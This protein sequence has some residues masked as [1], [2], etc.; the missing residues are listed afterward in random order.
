VDARFPTEAKKGLIARFTK[1]EIESSHS[2][3]RTSLFSTRNKNGHSGNRHFARASAFDLG[4]PRPLASSGHPIPSMESTKHLI[5]G[6]AGHI[7]HGKSTLVEALTG[8]NPDRLE[9]EK[10]RG[11]TIDLGFAFLDLEGARLGFVDV[12]GHERFVRNML[13]GVG[14][15]HLVLLVIA[16]DESIK[17]Q[18]REH[19]DICR[20]LGIPRGIIAITKSDL[21]DADVLGLV[22]LEI[23]EFV[24]GSFLESAPIIPVSAR[25]GAGLDALKQ[26]LR[27][28]AQS[29]PP[30]DSTRHFRLPIDRSFAMKGFGTVVTGTLVSGAVKVEDE[31]E[32]YPPRLRARV[33]GLHSGGKSVARAV[34]GQ[35]TAVNLAGIE[36]EEIERGMVLAPPGIFE[37]ARRLDARITLLGSARPLGSRARVHF[38]QG[39]A[40]VIAEI[41]LLGGNELAPGASAFAQLR[42]EK[43]VLLL[44]GDRFILRQ[45]S[46][47]ETIGG[48]VALDVR[49]A[50]HRRD[51]PAVAQF[52]ET[53]ERGSCEEILEALVAASPH[54]LT[55]LQ[56]VARTGWTET[57]ARQAATKPVEAK[58]LRVVAAQ[59]W[60][61]A[62]AKSVAD[63][64]AVLRKA[65]EEFHRAN[66]LSPGIPKQE[67]RGRVGKASAEIFAAALDDL[68][69][70]STLAISGDLV[71]RA[72]REIALSDE[73]AR[74]KELIE[75]E[76]ER[77]G[78]TVPSFVAV[79]EKL[80][81][82]SRRAQKILQI[83][84]RE[85][86]LIKVADDLVFHRAAVAGLRE[87]L[88]KYRKEHGERLPIPAFKELTG[89]TR[90]YAIPLLEY[91]DREHVTRRVGDERVIL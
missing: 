28:S 54:G 14:G 87:T 80:P 57:D 61:I 75:R 33:R 4:S 60:T 86:V 3:Y 78:L 20:L 52:L 48:G 15:I 68:V 42:L 66:P 64:A 71:Q 6:T 39:T 81:V 27:R 62:S 77:S 83:L 84:L 22:L 25:T 40:E 46:P 24:H 41:V 82:E 76:F 45:F 91:L 23:E 1:L 32:L 85:K 56:I 16:A 53:L 35:R 10:R 73:E 89:I 69:K 34:A 47:V 8:T 17:P 31:V 90:K 65:I 63:C 12:P 26:E 70:A 13:A 36:R 21:V 37:P 49:A 30:R 50:R 19:F 55:L 38:H 51:D 7:D 2:Q 59:P 29:L 9:E 88:A 43:P 44:P 67:L 11:I 72:G 79:L 5:V 18:T 74:A 58:H